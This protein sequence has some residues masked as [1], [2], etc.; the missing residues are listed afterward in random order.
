MFYQLYQHYLANVFGQLTVVRYR[1]SAWNQTRAW[2]Y[3]YP[4]LRKLHQTVL[5][6]GQRPLKPRPPPR[7][8]QRSGLLRMPMEVL[9]IITEMAAFTPAK[10]PQKQ[11]RTA[12]VPSDAGF[13]IPTCLSCPKYDAKN[14]ARVC[15]Q[16]YLSVRRLSFQQVSLPVQFDSNG[17]VDVGLMYSKVMASPKDV[18]K[19][20][21]SVF[22]YSRGATFCPRSRW[23]PIDL[24]AL[25]RSTM[26]D[27]KCVSFSY[28]VGDCY[29]VPEVFRL[30]CSE[31]PSMRH[32]TLHIPWHD[33][34]WQGRG[35]RQFEGLLAA[36]NRV[37]SL[38]FHNYWTIRAL[39]RLVKRQ[40]Q[41]ITRLNI[42]FPIRH[43]A[44]IVDLHLPN[45]QVCQTS[46]HGDDLRRSITLS[47]GLRLGMINLCGPKTHTIVVHLGF[48]E[49]NFFDIFEKQ[50]FLQLFDDLAAQRPALK[51]LQVVE[52]PRTD[53][54]NLPNDSR[55]LKKHY[56]DS[57]VDDIVWKHMDFLDYYTS[58]HYDRA[59]HVLNVYSWREDVA[60]HAASL[61][62]V[63]KAPTP[64]L[65]D[66]ELRF[67]KEAVER[68]QPKY[69]ARVELFGILDYTIRSHED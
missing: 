17:K 40:G 56:S 21:R 14:L 6:F 62:I 8:Q 15:I 30:M 51:S 54:F 48:S 7:P 31:L 39:A 5:N 42:H 46:W 49:D 37:E 4:P 27:V 67:L 16:L 24:K 34:K 25:F 69:E 63:F 58:R 47:N 35:R 57:G 45:L 11:K 38:T 9:D 3:I 36:S 1:P 19:H 12:S 18:W 52:E 23:Q 44:Q 13:T 60:R 22:V 65:T 32:L 66:G 50:N 41:T 61:G 33:Q 43:P 10:P 2:P 29:H 55:T 28:G 20:C 64:R 68:Q 53:H 59:L 26:R